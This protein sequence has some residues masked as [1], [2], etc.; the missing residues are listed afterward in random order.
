ML[1]IALSSMA[2][3]T[4]ACGGRDRGAGGFSFTPEPYVT[5]PNGTPIAVDR[6]SCGPYIAD[7]VVARVDAGAGSSFEDWLSSVGFHVEWRVERV[8]TAV[9]LIRVPLGSVGTA[10][11][12]VREQAGVLSAAASYIGGIVEEPTATPPPGLECGADVIG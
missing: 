6:E 4:I 3:L 9:Y 11:E 5:I 7:Q 1:A 10:V 12:L 2:A 8:G